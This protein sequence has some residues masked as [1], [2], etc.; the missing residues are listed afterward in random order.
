MRNFVFIWGILFFIGLAIFSSASSPFD[1]EF[2][3][4][5]LGNCADKGACKTYCDDF[6]HKNECIVFAEKHGFATRQEAE[7]VENHPPVGPGGCNNVEECEGYCD[8]PSHTEECV[9]FGK[10]HGLLDKKEIQKGEKFVEKT[11]PGGC[12]NPEEC[13]AYCEDPGKKDEC[14]D[15]AVREGYMTREESEKARKFFGKTGPGGCREEHE[16]RAYCNDSSHLEECLEFGEREGLIRQE[17]AVKIRKL[18]FTEGPGGCKG[19]DECRIFCEDPA[20]HFTCV[21][22]AVE[23]KLMTQEES[24]RAK[25]ILGRT[26]PGGCKNLDECRGFC[27]KPE[28]AEACFEH[29]VS[30]GLIPPAEAER[31]RK[32]I[33]VVKEG[34]PGGCRG[35]AECKQYCEERHDECFQFVKR[36]GMIPPEREK[37]FEVGIK[38]QKKMKETGGPG[39]CRNDGECRIYCTDSLH[40]EECVAF[41]ATH[42]GLPETEAR[43][44]LQDFTDRK[45]E[46]EDF[47]PSEEDIKRYESQ[48]RNRFEE[49]KQ[50][51]EQFR[52][53]G[54]PEGFGGSEGK[55]SEMGF[56]KGFSG[57]AGP[58]GCTSPSE[59]IK[60][61]TEHRE[62]CFS[63]GPPGM[64]SSRP[65]EGGIPPGHGFP[66]LRN[67]LVVPAPSGE[68]PAALEQRS[69]RRT[70]SSRIKIE[71]NISGGFDVTLYDSDGIEEFLL[72]PAQGTIYNSSYYSGS[73]GCKQEFKTE[74]MGLSSENFPLDVLIVDCASPANRFETKSAPQGF[75]APPA[76]VPSQ[77]IPDSFSRPLSRPPGASERCP[78]MPTVDQCPPGYKK[79][80]AYSSPECGTYY[81]C[82]P[83]GAASTPQSSPSLT[84]PPSFDPSK[85]CVE[86][87]GTWDGTACQ[88]PT[89]V[90]DP[91]RV[92]TERGG[93]WD[94]SACKIPPH[95]SKGPEERKG[96]F[97]AMLDFFF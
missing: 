50:L 32:F 66:R 20:N 22:W 14:I 13:R 3:I 69:S 58:G 23:H 91:A 77:G 29:G 80:V 94:G 83:E 10:E 97:A 24:E 57:F 87:G 92:C 34:G 51:E 67:D 53:K 1:I 30:E 6:A 40:V 86:K 4:P 9:A 64:P 27:E 36:Q 37:D 89:S 52:G 63:F 78:L 74:R 43:R 47:G 7:E 61:C 15:F 76:V 68:V 5:E 39:G 49:F 60:Y 11:G 41:A 85:I 48:A 54:I 38:L 73:V 59:C 93:I 71:K 35:P 21:D 33:K 82:T 81:S 75:E 65:P 70:G 95:Q 19:Q 90:Q 31:A 79:T 28:N 18:G 46:Q 88:V 72:K 42:G 62:E 26:G 2:P 17:D 12:K 55:G 45:F 44:M 96:L 8:D 56:P 16:C 84:T 25:K